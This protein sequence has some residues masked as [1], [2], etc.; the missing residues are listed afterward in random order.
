MLIAIVDLS[1]LN[2]G[3][4]NKLKINY[5]LYKKF[6]KQINS[7]EWFVDKSDTSSYN[8]GGENTVFYITN[9]RTGQQLWISNSFVCFSDYDYHRHYEP[10]FI[11]VFG[12][13][14]LAAWIKAAPLIFKAR[15]HN[16]NITKLK[17]IK[18]RNAKIN[19][20]LNKYDE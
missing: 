5:S 13:F 6:C 8:I 12:L 20:L 17:L 11:N 9:S 1:K 19:A 16:A 15:I 7:G 3:T 10:E 4:M 18:S 14:K 2:G